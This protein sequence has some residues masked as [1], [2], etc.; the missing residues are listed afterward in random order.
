MTV[1]FSSFSAICLKLNLFEIY[2]K[3]PPGKQLYDKLL[4]NTLFKSLGSE[5]F[6]TFLKEFEYFWSN[7][8]FQN[9]E[10]LSCD[11]KAKF[12]ASL[13]SLPHHM[14][15]QKS[16]LAYMIIWCWNIAYYYPC[17]KQLCCLIFLWKLTQFFRI[18]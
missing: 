8:F 15:L 5:R 10:N 3:C 1:G 12:S 16:F 2:S 11:V 14:I 13:L 17:W 6:L 9:L 18:L 7:F 4:A